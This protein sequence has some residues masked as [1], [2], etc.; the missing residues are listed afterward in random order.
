MKNDTQTTGEYGHVFDTPVAE[1][2]MQDLIDKQIETGEPIIL[3]TPKNVTA[4]TKKALDKL[5]NN[6]VSKG[7][8]VVVIDR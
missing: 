1:I 4:E 7:A 6:F 5:N 3:T 8:K 2:D